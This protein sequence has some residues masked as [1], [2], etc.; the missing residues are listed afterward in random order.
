MGNA[1]LLVVVVAKDVG[2]RVRTLFGVV[3]STAVVVVVS[4]VVVS[5]TKKK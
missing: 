5:G 4:S 3:S 1:N 2:T